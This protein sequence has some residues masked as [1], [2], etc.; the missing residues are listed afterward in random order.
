MSVQ[1]ARMTTCIQTDALAFLHILGHAHDDDQY[2]LKH[3]NPQ[4]YIF[5]VFEAL[6]YRVRH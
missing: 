1:L 5:L 2:W 3:R 4:V 6:C